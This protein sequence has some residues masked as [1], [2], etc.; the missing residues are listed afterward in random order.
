MNDND[1][2]D[3]SELLDSET[4][5]KLKK[6]NQNKKLRRE[7]K[8]GFLIVLDSRTN[9]RIKYFFKLIQLL[10]RGGFLIGITK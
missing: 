10:P 9:Y 4:A 5:I 1:E 2:G 3:E 8:L 7:I 6:K